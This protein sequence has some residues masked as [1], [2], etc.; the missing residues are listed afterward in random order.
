MPFPPPEGHYA[1][2]CNLNAR[3]YADYMAAGLVWVMD[4]H[5]MDGI[6]TDGATMATP[7]QNL[8]AGAGYVDENGILRP[9]T[10]VFGVRDAM[11]RLYRIVKG[12]ESDGLFI[13]HMSFNLLL[14][15][16]AF[17]DIQYTGEHEDYENLP[18]VRLRFSSRPWGVQQVLLGSSTQCYASL[19]TM[20]ALLHGDGIFTSAAKGYEDMCRKWTNLRK[21][22]MAFDY[23]SA[24]WTPY[25]KNR[26][27]Y[28]ITDDPQVLASL[29]CHP[30]K[31]ALLVVGNLN[32]EAKTAS[33]QLNL[34]EFGLADTALAARNALTQAPVALAP[35]GKLSI[36]VQGKS[37]TLVVIGRN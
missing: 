3:G 33:L 24:Q 31:D 12:R 9:T 32:K 17:S 15:T 37:F 4:E 29:Y 14:P 25:F 30:G 20:I 5:H 36:L 18:L 16:V 28:Y 11:K 7:S 23:K 35:D 8:Y 27:K 21:A 10:P 13:N 2:T 22:Y 34:K 6:Y 19:H 1:L 26:G